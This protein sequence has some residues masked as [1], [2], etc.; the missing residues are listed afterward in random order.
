MLLNPVWLPD[1]GRGREGTN[2]GSDDVEVRL[3]TKVASRLRSVRVG[4]Y[5]KALKVH[6]DNLWPTLSHWHLF[7]SSPS[8]P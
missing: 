3:H 2:R 1:T 6:A 4:V 7:R 5:A 8:S